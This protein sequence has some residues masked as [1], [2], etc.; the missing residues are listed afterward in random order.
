MICPSC[1]QDVAP[2]VRGVRTYCAAC[3]APLPFTA[4]PEAVNIVGKPARVGGSVVR[5]LASLVLAGG[6]FTGL[7]FL[8]LAWLFGSITTLYVSGVVFALALVFSLPFFYASKRLHR[9]GDDSERAARERAV[10]A[11]AAQHR[12]VLTAGGVARSLEIPEETADALLTDLAKRAD[13]QVSLEVDDGG[14]L[15]YVFRDLVASAPGA[16]VRIGADGWRAPAPGSNA[17]PRV[18]D[19]ELIDEE[20]EPLPPE[21]RRMTR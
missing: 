9:A 19:A 18:V 10:F 21:Q 16:R 13:G 14:A 3:G 4:A 17:A 6:I 12:G 7:F 15:S 2:I 1:R 8:F 20:E 5:V 11:L